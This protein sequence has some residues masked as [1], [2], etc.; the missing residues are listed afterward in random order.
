LFVSGSEIGWDLGRTSGSADS[1]FYSDSLKAKYAGDDSN[2]DTVTA[3]A[4]GIFAGLSNF[5]FDT[6]RGVTYAVDYPDQLNTVSSSSVSLV[7][8]GGSGGNAAVEYKGTFKVV[9]FGFPFETIL[10]QSTRN[11][12]MQRILNF[13]DAEPVPVELS[14]F[15]AE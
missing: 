9:N 2:T 7:Y 4:T 5:A 15:K 11:E 6:G 1:T 13:L 14:R 8:S 10:G 12:V 3:S